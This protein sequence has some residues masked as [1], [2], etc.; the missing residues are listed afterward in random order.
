MFPYRHEGVEE[1]FKNRVLRNE[2]L[3]DFA[4]IFKYGVIVY[5][6]LIEG[7][8]QLRVFE[9]AGHSRADIAL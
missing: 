3:Y 2:F 6:G 1:V 8:V 4:D 5:G 7:N 9:V